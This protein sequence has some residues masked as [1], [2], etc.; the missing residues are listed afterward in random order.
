[1]GTWSLEDSQLTGQAWRRL[2][3]Y[4]GFLRRRL[5]THKSASPHKSAG[6]AMIRQ[7]D[8]DPATRKRQHGRRSRFRAHRS[9]G[10]ALPPAPSENRRSLRH[11]KSIQRNQ[12]YWREAEQDRT[13]LTC[14]RLQRPSRNGHQERFDHSHTLQRARPSANI[15]AVPKE[16]TGEIRGSHRWYGRWETR[17]FLSNSV[18]VRANRP[19]C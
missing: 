1:M 7:I 15:A 16:L 11:S 14:D 9:Y 12:A 10:L 19:Y 8:F 18:Q 3:L 4:F 17:D 13:S 6:C 5:A 2:Q